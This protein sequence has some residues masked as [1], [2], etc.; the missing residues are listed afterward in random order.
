MTKQQELI[1]LRI[2]V[3]SKVPRLILEWE[4]E[5]NK[6]PKL[7]KA[8]EGEGEENTYYIFRISKYTF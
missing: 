4:D 2:E 6:I 7:S 3:E 8:E 5:V 1:N